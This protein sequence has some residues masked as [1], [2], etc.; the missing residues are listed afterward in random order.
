MRLRTSSDVSTLRSRWATP[1]FA[2]ATAATGASAEAAIA[3]DLQPALQGAGWGHDYMCPEHV[4]GLDWLPDQPAEHRCPVGG[5]FRTGPAFDAGWRVALNGRIAAGLSS[6]ATSYLATGEARYRDHVVAILLRYAELYPAL[7]PNGTWVGRGRVTGQ[8]LEEAVWGIGVAWAYDAVADTLTPSE[9]ALLCG[10]LRQVADHVSE[11]L[12][13]RIHNIECWHLA[14]LVTLAV[15]LDDDHLRERS[16]RGENGLADQLAEGILRDGWWAEGSPSYHYYMLSSALWSAL[17]LREVDPEFTN[18]TRL[19]R[20]FTSPLTMLRSDGS[21]PALNDGWLAVAEPWGIGQYAAQ[22]EQGFGLF[23]DD[24]CAWFLREA[25]AHGHERR[26]DW[27]LMLGPSPE[28]LDA[29][30]SAPEPQRVFDDS[31][32]AFLT[33]GRGPDERSVMLKYG[34]HGG[35][36]GHPDKLEIDLHAFGRRLAGDDGSPSYNSPLQ[37]PWVRQTLSHNTVLLDHDSQPEARGRLLAFADAGSE[38]VGL[39]DAEVSWAADPDASNGPPGSWLAEPRQRHHPAYAGSVIRRLLLA[40]PGPDDPGGYLL[41]VVLV[42]AVR[43]V[44]IDL[45]FH[46]RG[47]VF[48]RRSTPSRPVDFDLPNETYA[49][50]RDVHRLA[51]AGSGRETARRLEFGFDGGATTL[52]L[53]RG[54]GGQVLQARVPGNPPAES[55]AL[56][57]RRASGGT[58]C[59][60]SVLEASAHAGQNVVHDVVVQGDTAG[61]STNLAIDVDVT[62]SAGVDRWRIAPGEGDE[63]AAGVQTAGAQRAI[64]VTLGRGSRADRSRMAA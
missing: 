47:S 27:A 61:W 1:G 56:V 30:G 52:W 42:D 6:C 12:L 43:P 45:A 44:D 54:D 24:D 4:V 59:F 57:L 26:S 33:T 16:L 63:T 7:P 46:H 64:T 36:H 5:E 25:Y 28:Q 31:G 11:Q 37:G 38:P 34:R 14:C 8:S 19:R 58:A 40:A 49:H 18:G 21:L 22:Y 60:V 15:V 10:L 3:A 20:S 35:G 23:G 29:R 51:D 55:Q 62:T 2:A 9:D 53:G 48:S 17:A 13:E 41:D 39:I 32:Y 50:L